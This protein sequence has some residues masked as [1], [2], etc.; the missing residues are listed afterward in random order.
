MLSTSQE[1]VYEG[2]DPILVALGGEQYDA[3]FSPRNGKL[4]PPLLFR[5]FLVRQNAH[6]KFFCI[7]LQR[8]ILVSNGNAE[9]LN[10]LN[11]L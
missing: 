3:C 8:P 7:E 5:E 11:R 6:T 4:D 1:G 9:E 10:S 2:P